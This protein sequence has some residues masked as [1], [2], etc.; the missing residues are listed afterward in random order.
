VNL[1]ILLGVASL[2]T[3]RFY[4]HVAPAWMVLVASGAA[5]L[6]VT[7]GVRR[8]LAGGHDGAR[9]G[10]TAEP[11]FGDPTRRHATEIVGTVAAFAPPAAAEPAAARRGRTPW[12]RA[13]EV[14][15][16]AERRATS[17]GSPRVSPARSKTPSAVFT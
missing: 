12:S 16:V 7:L 11:L 8:L 5:A 17:E 4:V 3:L 9:G 1:G 14:S 15:A 13:A 6:G 2:V 10:F